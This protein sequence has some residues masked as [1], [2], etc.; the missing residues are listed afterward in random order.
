MYKLS[1]GVINASHIKDE[2]DSYIKLSGFALIQAKDIL[3]NTYYIYRNED[4]G[5]R[6]CDLYSLFLH[7]F[8]CHERN[9][10]DR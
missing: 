6:K 3:K 8:V 4:F 1:A 7:S 5:P 10:P 9:P 2:D